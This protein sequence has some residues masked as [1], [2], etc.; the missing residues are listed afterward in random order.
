MGKVYGGSLKDV[1]TS[2]LDIIIDEKAIIAIKR[3]LER[4]SG[5]SLYEKMGRATLAA[6]D[7]LVPII[8]AETPRVT[9]HLYRYTKARPAKKRFGNYLAPTLGVLVGPT[10]PHRHLVIRGHRIVTPGGIYTGR[11]TAPNP[12]VDRAAKGFEKKAAEI[13]RR[14]WFGDWSKAA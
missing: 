12:Y 11:R 4:A 3:K 8:K 1:H 6:A 2:G 5:K 9:G 7:L 13:I 14:E 10:S